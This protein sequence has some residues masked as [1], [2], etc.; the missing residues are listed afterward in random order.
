MVDAKRNS[1]SI[2]QGPPVT[3]RVSLQISLQEAS[4]SVSDDALT[5][6]HG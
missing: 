2:L 1:G 5:F 4:K 6:T 3:M